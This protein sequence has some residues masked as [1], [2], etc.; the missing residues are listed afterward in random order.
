MRIILYVYKE[1]VNRHPNMPQGT[2]VVEH[3][4]LASAEQRAR[5]A[6]LNI[7]VTVQFPLLHNFAGISEVYFGRDRVSHI[8][9]V[10]QWFDSGVLTTAGSDFPVGSYVAMHSLEGLSTRKPVIG[11]LREEH[12]LTLPEVVSL[13]TTEAARTLGESHLRRMLTPGRF[14]DI[15]IWRKDPFDKV[16]ILVD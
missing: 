14:A 5:A 1:A 4:G 2:L 15:T 8:L 11:V 9:P 16:S 3:G 13:R 10:R 6:T 7:P 12:A